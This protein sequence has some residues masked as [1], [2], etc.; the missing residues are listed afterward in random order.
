MPFGECV[1]KGIATFGTPFKGSVIA[2]AVEPVARYLPFPLNMSFVERLKKTREAE[3]E[4]MDLEDED[5]AKIVEDFEALTER[6]NI[7]L[8]KFWERKPLRFMGIDIMP[9]S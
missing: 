3:K 8:F 4:T 9:V 1:V 7:P 6:L 2:D 5:V